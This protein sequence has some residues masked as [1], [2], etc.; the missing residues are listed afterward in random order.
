MESNSA[1]LITDLNMD[2]LEK[3]FRYLDDQHLLRIADCFNKYLKSVAD[4]VFV[5]RNGKR[6][7]EITRVQS[8]RPSYD[9]FLIL[10]H[11]L[12]TTNFALSLKLLRCFGH[13]LSMLHLEIAFNDEILVDRVVA[14]VKKYV[15]FEQLTDVRFRLQPNVLDDLLNSVE[16][17]FSNAKCVGIVGGTSI[18]QHRLNHLFPEMQCLNVYLFHQIDLRDIA[19]HFPHLKHLQ[20]YM[21]HKIEI[22]DSIHTEFDPIFSLNPQLCEL[23]LPIQSHRIYP[24]INEMLPSLESLELN[25]YRFRGGYNLELETQHFMRVQRFKLDMGCSEYL[26]EIL[27]FRFD[28][29]TELTV[30]SGYIDLIK[31]REFLIRYS[32]VTKLT[33]RAEKPYQSKYLSLTALDLAN[34]LPMLN[35][36][37]LY[38]GIFCPNEILCLM[39]TSKSLQKKRVITRSDADYDC[40]RLNMNSSWHMSTFVPVDIVINFRATHIL[41]QRICS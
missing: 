8:Y 41:L 16:K 40:I 11:K 15:R 1:M 26:Y 13:L 19:Y 30:Y 38:R 23:I 37:S 39:K 22:D 18:K 12:Q 34:T 6:I 7:V 17:P 25:F 9:E 24:R 20:L 3:I 33:L 36:I 29:L 28:Y 32:T 14:Y 21:Y 5:L 31:L 35:E 2:C 10:P 4:L 27:P